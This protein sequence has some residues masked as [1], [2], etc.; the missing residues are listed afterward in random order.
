M[1]T[2]RFAVRKIPLISR[3]HSCMNN[4]GPHSRA[5]RAL[6]REVSSCFVSSEIL[7]REKKHDGQRILQ[8]SANPHHCAWV[9]KT[10]VAQRERLVREAYRLAA[11]QQAQWSRIVPRSAGEHAR[12]S[13]AR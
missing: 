13:S 2:S 6:L 12:T 11:K 3:T 7:R 9:W 1:V 4:E 8:C 5:F 10:L